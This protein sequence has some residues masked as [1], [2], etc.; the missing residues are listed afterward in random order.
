MTAVSAGFKF[1]ISAQDWRGSVRSGGE[2]EGV[3][4]WFIPT[5]R[6]VVGGIGAVATLAEGGGGYSCSGKKVKKYFRLFTF[7]GVGGVKPEYANEEVA[8]WA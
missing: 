5:W 8:C 6:E 7:S 1:S 3:K 2:E 4:R